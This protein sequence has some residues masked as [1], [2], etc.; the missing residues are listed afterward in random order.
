MCSTSRRPG[1]TDLKELLESLAHERPVFH[2]EADFQH[3]LAWHWQRREPTAAIRLEYRLPFAE[4]RGYADLWI[5]DGGQTT[6]VELKYWT[7]ALS[8]QQGDE[9]YR[10]ANQAAQ[11]ISR[12]D[13][14]MDLARV[15]R[16]VAAGL[17]NR[18]F[19]VALTNDQGYWSQPR[20]GTVD[21]AFRLHEGRTLLGELAWAEHAGV[22]TTATRQRVLSLAR[23]YRCH[24]QPYSN[25]DVPRGEFRYLLVEVPGLS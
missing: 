15:E 12:Y 13:F 24:W 17:A 21:A 18:G 10:L 9:T 19:V 8:V 11:D 20:P 2:S 4:E 5:R 3:A 14:I 6:Y 23:E 7:R 22:G 1:V 16:A 25:L